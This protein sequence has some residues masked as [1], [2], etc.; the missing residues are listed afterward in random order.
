MPEK[1]QRIVAIGGGGFQMEGRASPID[2]YVVT[3]TGKATPRICLLS[4]PSGDRPD[5]I[6]SFHSAYAARGCEPSHIAFFERDPQRGAVPLSNL[7]T[8]LLEQDAVFVSGGNTRAAIAVWREW[9]V[10]RVF[11][12]AL[13]QGVLLAGM[14]A[15]AMCWFEWALTDTYWRHGYRPIQALGFVT[16]GC[17]VHYSA[18][19]EQRGRLHAALLAGA[20]PP[21]LAITDGAAAVYEAGVLDRVVTWQPGASAYHLRVV[22]GRVHEEAYPHDTLVDC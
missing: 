18:A 19:S 11:A 6:D 16:G 2:D 15:G 12:K 5:C 7:E 9:H 3:L 4:T 14:S 1:R 21:T 17:R 22:A 8:H 13:D 10:E 20:V